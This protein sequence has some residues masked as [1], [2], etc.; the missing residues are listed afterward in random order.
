MKCG[1]EKG[2]EK[3]DMV[4]KYGKEKGKGRLGDDMWQRE[5]KRQIG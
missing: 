2:K 4:M 5:R 3:E 1:K